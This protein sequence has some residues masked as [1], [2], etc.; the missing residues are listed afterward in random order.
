MHWKKDSSSS[1]CGLRR[2]KE[3][4]KKSLL[5]TD[6]REK[7]D[8]NN[9]RTYSGTERKIRKLRGKGCIKE[10][11]TGSQKDATITEGIGKGLTKTG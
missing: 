2:S 7:Q 3:G 1:P 10:K 5:K 6:E 4:K 11:S 9:L 8:I